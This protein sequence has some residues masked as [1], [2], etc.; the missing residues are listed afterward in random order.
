MRALILVLATVYLLG[1][2]ALGAWVASGI[3][4]ELAATHDHRC[5]YRRFFG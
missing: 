5:H 2:S 4:S 1:L 3:L